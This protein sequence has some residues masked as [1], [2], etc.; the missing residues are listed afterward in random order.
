MNRTNLRAQSAHWSGVLSVWQT[1]SVG[2]LCIL[3][4]SVASAEGTNKRS[5]PIGVVELF[6][7]QGCYSCPPADENL[8]QMLEAQLLESEPEMLALE[9]HVDYWNELVW[10]SDGTWVDPFSKP[11]YTLRQRQYEQA[12]LQGRTGVYTPQGIINGQYAMVGINKKRT[13][14]ALAAT[15]PVDVA[16]NVSAA[17]GQLLVSVDNPDALQGANIYLARFLKKTSTDI[18]GGENN[19]KQLH[20]VNVVT[21]YQSLGELAGETQHSFVVA[22]NIDS[23]TGCAIV[24][25]SERLGPILGAAL[26]P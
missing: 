19:R 1:I 2:L 18:T 15:V 21:E 20:N 3:S 8:A 13:K 10:G 23:N 25:Q 17:D 5:K 9:F 11:E 16:V 4:I 6:T 7:S 22:A 14:Q 24:V 26:C 12:S